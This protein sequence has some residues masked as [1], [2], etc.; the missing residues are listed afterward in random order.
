[1]PTGFY[2]LQNMANLSLPLSLS[3]FL[4]GPESPSPYGILWPMAFF[5]DSSKPIKKQVLNIRPAPKNIPFR[6]SK[7]YLNG[8]SS[9][10]SHLL[11]YY[12]F[13]TCEVFP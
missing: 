6:N 7:E 3:L 13:P 8:L 5:A 4:Q 9:K 10:D 12:N 2:Y 11:S 1:M